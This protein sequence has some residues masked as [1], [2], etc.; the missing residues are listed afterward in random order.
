MPKITSNPGTPYVDGAWDQGGGQRRTTIFNPATEQPIG[1][2]YESSVDDVNRAV[3]AARRAFS[4]GR[5]EWPKMT[6]KE[7]SAVL[8]RFADAV[9][10]RR[11]DLNFL[12]E[13]ALGG[14]GVA[15]LRID[16]QGKA[17]AQQLLE[18]PVPVPK[19]LAESLTAAIAS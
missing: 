2:V 6:P 14:G 8:H 1:E 19:A 9:A 3:E 11:E 10:A 17:F 5:G 4:D 15:S 12:L 18:F 13:N 7:R 16:P